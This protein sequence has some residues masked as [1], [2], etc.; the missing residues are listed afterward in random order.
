M[1]SVHSRLGAALDSIAAATGVQRM[2]VHD[3]ERATRNGDT[4]VEARLE[5][6][7]SRLEVVAD[8]LWS[9]VESDRKHLRRAA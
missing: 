4:S 7:V 3:A 9:A 5:L 8:D 6:V 1:A 2:R